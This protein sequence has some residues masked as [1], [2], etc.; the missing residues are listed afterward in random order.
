MN[1]SILRRLALKGAAVLAGLLSL[2]SLPALAEDVLRV[3]AIPDEAPTELQRKFAPLGRYLEAQTGMKVVF[4][5]VSDY[6]AVV[7]SLATRKI[8]LAWL[9]GF[10]YVQ[11][12]IRTNG[13]AVPLVQ[14]EED[15]RFT[16]RFITAD[17]AIK[18]LADLKGRSFAF[19]SPSSTSGHLMPRYF[20]QEAGLNPDKDFKTI[21]FSGAHDA[22][23]AFVAA[24]KAEA[25]VLNAS[26]WDKLVEQKKV[27]P[28]KVR[29]FAT[30]PAYFDYNWT[31]RGD[32]DTALVNKIADAF[33]KLD[34]A[35]PEH[36]EI[37]AL[38][39]ASR[40]IPTRKENY[41]GIEKAA[42]AAGLLK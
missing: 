26:V 19:G 8:D 28:D 36:K 5:P 10:T 40:F 25:G 38:Q 6:A 39:R 14:R 11:A 31:V 4:T 16:S 7:E 32:L 3:S 9:G 33:L 18:S 15:A 30:T 27:D 24:G 23:V 12:R 17:P 34:P 35:N 21:A 37:M 20:L 13:T 29:V 2:A 41:A 42:Q 22:T 1:L